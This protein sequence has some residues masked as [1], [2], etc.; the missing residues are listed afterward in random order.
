MANNFFNKF[1]IP[2]NDNN[3]NLLQDSLELYWKMDVKNESL[4]LI[5]PIFET[6]MLGLTPAVFPP[7]LLDVEGPKLELFDLDQ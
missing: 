3:L 1:Q 4:K 5:P 6:P 2:K 7:I